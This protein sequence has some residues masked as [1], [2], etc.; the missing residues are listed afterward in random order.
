[1]AP[2]SAGQQ[3][4]ETTGSDFGR[5]AD[6]SRPALV[7]GLAGLVTLR[8]DRDGSVKR[9]VGFSLAAEVQ[10]MSGGQSPMSQGSERRRTT[11]AKRRAEFDVFGVVAARI[12]ISAATS[13]PIPD[14][15]CC[16]LVECSRSFSANRCRRLSLIKRSGR[17]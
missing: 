8:A 7:V 16:Q 1:M 17:A 4:L 14:V 10:P 2:H 15:P 6:L 5:E 13:G 3:T 11:G 12:I 9:R